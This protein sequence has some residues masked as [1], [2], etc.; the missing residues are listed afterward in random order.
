MAN[1]FGAVWLARCR[2]PWP[3]HFAA[4]DE[5]GARQMP[6]TRRPASSHEF[7]TESGEIR[8][9]ARG[10]WCDTCRGRRALALGRVSDIDA[11]QPETGLAENYP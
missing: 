11:I 5:A 3:R 1:G 9:L 7:R 4:T 10:S 2:V 6:E 8:P